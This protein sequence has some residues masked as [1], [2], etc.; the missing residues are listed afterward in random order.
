MT[1]KAIPANPK[2]YE[3]IKEKVKKQ[4]DR[5]PSAYASGQVVQEY[6]A[7]M[8]KKGLKPY[9]DSK[10]D[11]KVGLARWYKEGWIDIK[12]GKPCGAV[13]TKDYYPTCRPAKRVTNKTPVTANELTKSQKKAMIEK[14]QDAKEKRVQ[15]KETKS[16]RIK[17]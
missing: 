16:A 5:W 17:K 11:S 12:T 13:K 7:E 6:K 15:Y 2:L 9:L 1:N 3:K 8:K 14:K 4:V 10:P